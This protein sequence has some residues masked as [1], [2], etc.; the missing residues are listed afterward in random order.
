MKGTS[1]KSVWQIAVL[2][3]F[4]AV[5]GM[6][7]YFQQKEISLLRKKTE[8]N[9]KE[10]EVLRIDINTKKE[11][12]SHE[13]DKQSAKNTD[14]FFLQRKMTEM[15]KEIER[16]KKN[17]DSDAL[18]EYREK[19]E[20]T[21][22]EH[23]ENVKKLWSG[24]LKQK[25]IEQKF[26]DDEIAEVLH[27]YSDMIDK[28]KAYSLSWYREEI[29]NEELNNVSVQYAKDFYESSSSLFGEQKASLVLG[30]VFPD[31]FF[32]KSLFDVE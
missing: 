32:R 3:F 31:P 26:N 10:I 9:A 23:T 18:N 15:K 2:I 17:N 29:S 1:K 11:N 25:L 21:W 30:V 4:F 20:Q 19:E 6:V 5:T 28:M 7:L 27:N 24:N 13:S 22:D 14:L 12:V 8:I 16:M